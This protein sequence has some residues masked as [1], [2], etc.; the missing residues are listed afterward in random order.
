MD[1]RAAEGV[2]RGGNQSGTALS[3]LAAT[4]SNPYVPEIMQPV[5]NLEENFGK[6]AGHR[7]PAV[8]DY[9][10]LAAQ[11]EKIIRRLPFPKGVYRFHTHEEADAW[12]EKHMMAAAVKKALAR[13]DEPT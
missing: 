5:A 13:Q 3:A 4:R 10:A 11:S 7:K 9:D 8:S 2:D 12:L 1:A 6:I